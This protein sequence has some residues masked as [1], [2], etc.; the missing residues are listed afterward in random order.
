MS[1]RSD[2]LWQIG[3]DYPGCEVESDLDP[4]LSGL[5]ALLCEHDWTYDGKWDYCA[6]H[7]DCQDA[8]AVLIFLAD[9]GEGQR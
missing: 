7:R 9:E 5:R 1:A 6:E 3:C 2:V 8:P 4:S